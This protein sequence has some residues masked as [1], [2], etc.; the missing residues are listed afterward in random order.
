MFHTIVYAYGRN[1]YSL[2]RSGYFPR[3]LSVTHP[4]RKTPHVALIGGAVVGYLVALTLHLLPQ[5]SPVGAVLLN[6]AVFGAVIA[7]IMQML[8][9]VVLRRRYPHIHRPYVSRLGIPGAVIS[10][11]ISAVT[12]VYLFY[13]PDYNLGVIGCALWFAGAVAYFWLHGRHHL[14]KSPEEAFAISERSRAVSE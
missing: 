12:L 8:A 9:F 10:G 5:D 6:M 11:V 7:Y 13:N 14:V 3:G 2:S 1:I 4:T